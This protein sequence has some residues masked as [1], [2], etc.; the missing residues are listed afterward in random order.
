[1]RFMAGLFSGWLL[2]IAWCYSAGS[3]TPILFMSE[4]SRARPR[5]GLLFFMRRWADCSPV[6]CWGS[7]GRCASVNRASPAVGYASRLAV[8]HLMVGRPGIVER[9]MGRAVPPLRTA[10]REPNTQLRGAVTTATW[11]QPAGAGR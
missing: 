2:G 11:R 1:M 6:A 4:T 5:W 7:G 3:L 8:A 9:H 10:C